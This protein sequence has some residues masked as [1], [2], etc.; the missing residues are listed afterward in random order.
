MDEYVLIMDE[1]DPTIYE[2]VRR[3]QDDDDD[4]LT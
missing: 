1:F 2:P 4:E 3:E